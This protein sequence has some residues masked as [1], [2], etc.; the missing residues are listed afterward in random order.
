M[1]TLQA[2]DQRHSIRQYDAR[3]VEQEKIDR[4][5]DEVEK[6]NKESG[7][8]IQLV[9]DEPTAFDTR[10]AH[11]GK[12]AGVRNYFALVGKK[13]Y[14]L[15]EQLGYYGA[16]LCLLAV[17]LGLGTCWV[18]LT[19][20]KRKEFVEVLPGEKFVAVI[21]F[22]YAAEQPKHHKIKTYEQVTDAPQDAP[23]WF[24]RGVEAALKA[25][26]AVNQQKFKI[27]LSPD[28]T[29][30]FRVS[31][32]GFFTKMDLGIVRYFFEVGKGATA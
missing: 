12:F 20:S 25:P 11:Y 21:C 22:G 1:N 13:T 23:A 28:G 8:H 3:P 4:L 9:T 17:T 16:R 6:I 24:R 14:N 29:V 19:F 10:M 15:D 32:M 2:I 5:Y 30:A 31:G 27:T 26:T 7:L 18:G